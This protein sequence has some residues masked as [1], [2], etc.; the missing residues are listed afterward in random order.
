M[1][2][3]SRHQLETLRKIAGRLLRIDWEQVDKE[4]SSLRARDRKMVLA[5]GEAYLKLVEIRRSDLPAT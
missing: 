5:L 4:A 2:N 1:N 3:L